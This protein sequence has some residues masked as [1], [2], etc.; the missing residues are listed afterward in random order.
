MEYLMRNVKL[1][2]P[3]MHDLYVKQ[4]KAN[5]FDNISL[6]EGLPPINQKQQ[7]PFRDP[8][9][10]RKQRYRPFSPTLRV[11]TDFESIDKAR[12]QMKD[13]EV[14]ERLHDEM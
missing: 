11:E 13:K 9:D 10:V 5:K 12:K 1:D 2:K 6:P 7:G 8:I 3:E 14:T 4:I